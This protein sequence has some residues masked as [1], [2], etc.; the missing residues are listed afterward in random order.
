MK[1]TNSLEEY[2]K[3]IYVLV[4]TEKQARVTTI[5][6]KMN[7]SKPSVNRALNTLKEEN[8]VFYEAYGDIV[9]TSKGIEVARKIVKRYDTLKLFLTEVLEVEENKAKDEAEFMKHTVSEDTILKL[10]RYINKIL[11]LG[12]L[13]C[14]YDSNNTKCKTCIKLTAKNR[15]KKEIQK[16][17]EEI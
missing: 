8:L 10:E 16:S 3:T 4:T 1:L 13:E 5:S 15:L 12:D 11:D 9:L 2:L 6:K 17:K 14:C 7:C